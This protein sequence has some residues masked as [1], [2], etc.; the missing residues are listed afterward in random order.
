LSKLSQLSTG[1]SAVVKSFTDSEVA[2][3]LI[4]LGCTQGITVRVE[5]SAP[6]GDPLMIS[7]ACTFLSLRKSEAES[8][9]VVIP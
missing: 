5:Q 2:A 7:F 4:E 6:M 1:A 9:E 3:R 8:I